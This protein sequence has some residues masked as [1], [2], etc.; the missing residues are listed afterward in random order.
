MHTCLSQCHFISLPYLHLVCSLLRI[1]RFC[2]PWTKWCDLLLVTVSLQS[3]LGINW[4]R[5]SSLLRCF[6]H[7]PRCCFFPSHFPNR[8]LDAWACRHYQDPQ[9]WWSSEVHY[10][11]EQVV[12]LSRHL[13]SVQNP[14]EGI[15]CRR[16]TSRTLRACLLCLPE[17]LPSEYPP[18]SGPC[19]PHTPGYVRPKISPNWEEKNGLLSPSWPRF[20]IM[21]TF[22]LCFIWINLWKPHF[23]FP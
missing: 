13:L 14:M 17:A 21:K 5:Y 22:Y 4:L 7:A 19:S 16:I 2:H 3:K 6:L 23:V 1:Q 11:T 9:V 18:G 12:S 20:H 10:N 15:S 8:T